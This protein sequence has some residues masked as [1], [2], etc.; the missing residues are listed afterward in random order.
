MYVYVGNNPILNIDPLGLCAEQSNP[1][2]DMAKGVAFGFMATGV[3][4]IEV[5]KIVAADVTKAVVGSM[6]P[7]PHAV[8][9]VADKAYTAR[10]VYNNVTR[11]LRETAERIGRRI[12]NLR[13]WWY[14]E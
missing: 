9:F 3:V 8:E 1:I 7:L 2:K 6:L 12:E 13:K 11:D 5:A 14:G 4:T 10:E